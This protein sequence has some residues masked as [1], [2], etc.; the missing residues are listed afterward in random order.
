MGHVLSALAPVLIH[1]PKPSS[2][3][4][5][6]RHPKQGELLNA[7]PNF[8]QVA[9]RPPDIHAGWGAE[10]V[11]STDPPAPQGRFH[12][13]GLLLFYC[14]SLVFSTGLQSSSGNLV[15]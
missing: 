4:F 14:Q 12:W 10:G 2:V 8:G 9:L 13:L 5:R 1:H 3:S 6:W 15:T 11:P 7:A